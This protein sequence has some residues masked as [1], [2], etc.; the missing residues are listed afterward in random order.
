MIMMHQDFMTTRMLEEMECSFVF[1]KLLYL[2]VDGDKY[3]D[4][5]SQFYTKVEA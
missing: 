3:N 5:V 1:D 2:V 4:I